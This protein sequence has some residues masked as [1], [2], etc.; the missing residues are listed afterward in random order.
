MDTDANDDDRRSDAT[1]PSTRR[2][3]T[4]ETRNI[5][6]EIG[7]QSV[8]DLLDG[9]LGGG[10][11]ANRRPPS[12]TLPNER[13]NA[14]TIEGVTSSGDDVSDDD[15][16]HVETYR[17]DEEF[18]VVADLPGVSE[19]ELSAGVS[20]RSNELVVAVDGNTVERIG[21]PWD[22]VTA[23]SARFNNFVLEIHLGPAIDDE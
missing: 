8:T 16:F 23:T 17:T 18:V 20:E 21:L 9:L 19:D 5:R 11:P 3:P 10:Q 4:D 12:R 6:I 1:D 7:L 14:S 22:R 2:S 13:D 15:V